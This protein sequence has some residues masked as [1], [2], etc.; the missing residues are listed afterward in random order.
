MCGLCCGLVWEGPSQMR[1]GSCARQG[2]SAKA[3]VITLETGQIARRGGDGLGDDVLDLLRA[4]SI[5][6]SG[7]NADVHGTCFL[8]VDVAPWIEGRSMRVCTPAV[9]VGQRLTSYDRVDALRG[10]SPPAAG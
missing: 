7:R 5:E 3:T 9:K 10:V 2:G 6:A 4:G 8:A 1:A